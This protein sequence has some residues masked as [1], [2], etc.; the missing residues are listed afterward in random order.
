M[1]SLQ[2]KQITCQVD[3]EDPL[4]ELPDGRIS[5]A[6]AATYLGLSTKTLANWRVLGRGPT[7]GSYR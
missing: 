4:R 7:L 2:L 6:D 5:S 3:S 1:M